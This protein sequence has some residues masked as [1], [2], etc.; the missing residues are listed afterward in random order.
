MD[1]QG[2]ILVRTFVSPPAIVEMVMEGVCILLGKKYSWKQ[3]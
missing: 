1:K 2:L 3:A